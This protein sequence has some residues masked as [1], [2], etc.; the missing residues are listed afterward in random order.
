MNPPP[1]PATASPEAP[2]EAAPEATPAIRSTLSGGE[3]RVQLPRRLPIVRERTTQSN[4]PNERATRDRLRSL[5]AALVAERAVVAPA[6]IL[7][8][9]ELAV[10]VIRRADVDDV[11]IDYTAVLLNNE[12]WRDELA[13]VPYERR[14]LLLPKCLRVEEH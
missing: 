5:A 14:L 10:E 6:S 1:D 11:F 2:T 12:V 8:L 4:I 9:R 3:T 7:Q 13:Q